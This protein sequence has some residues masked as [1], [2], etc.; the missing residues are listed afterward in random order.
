MNKIFKKFNLGGKTS[1]ITGASVLLG[2]EN[3]FAYMNERN[4]ILDSER[5]TW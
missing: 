4:V 1:I 5:I 2:I 3:A